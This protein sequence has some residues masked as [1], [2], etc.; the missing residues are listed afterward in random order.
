MKYDVFIS[1]KRQSINIV[2]A[3]EYILDN[4]GIKC[5]YDSGLEVS[6]G[7]DYADIIAKKISESKIMIAVLSN[8]ALESDWV[9]AEVSS[10]LEQKKLVI[11][12]IVGKIQVNNGLTLQ[13]RSKQW[14]DAYPNPDRKFELLLKNVK[15][16]L[17]ELEDTMD[18]GDDEKSQKKE[19][20]FT[21]E[22]DDCSTDFDYDEGMALYEGKEY[23][24][25]ALALFASAERGNRNAKNV[26]CQMFYDLEDEIQNFDDE[27]W[28]GIEQQA[29][30]N[31]CYANFLM[32]CKLYKEAS[33]NLVSFEYLKKA[34][35][36]NSVPLAFLRL[37]IQYSWGMGIKQSHTLGMHYYKKALDMGCKEAYSYMGQEYSMG[38]DK[39][40]KD[41]DK[42]ISL[43]NKGVEAGDQRSYKILCQTYLFDLKQKDE[44]IVV[45]SR[46]I[47]RGFL[48]GFAFM[49]DIALGDG[50]RFVADYDEAIKWYKK[51]LLN[52]EKSAY[53]ML[54]W[55]YYW[56]GEED[57]AILMAKKG[58]LLRDSNSYNFLA[59][60]YKNSGE[61]ENAWQCCKEWYDSVGIGADVMTELVLEN[62]YFPAEVE[63][64]EDKN[65]F[66]DRLEQIV[67]IQA[68][69]NSQACL[70]ALLK[71]YS[72]RENGKIAIDYSIGQRIPKAFEI[73]RIGAEMG[74]PEMMYYIGKGMMDN[75]EPKNY[76]PIKGLEWIG[77]AAEN[78]YTPAIEDLLEI[79][80]EGTWM[81]KDEYRKTVLLSLGNYS[82]SNEKAMKCL[83]KIS[84]TEDSDVETVK[85]FLESII[86][87]EHNKDLR[88]DAIKYILIWKDSLRWEP[89]DSVTSDIR[90]FLEAV[91][92]DND[93]GYIRL[94]GPKALEYF[95]EY[96]RQHGMDDFFNGRESVDADLF[97]AFALD[98]S[99][100]EENKIR[101]HDDILLPIFDELR[102]LPAV[103]R[104][105]EI[106][107]STY[108]GVTKALILALNNF[109]D[110]LNEIC[111]THNLECSIP[112]EFP[113][114]KFVPTM[115]SGEVVEIWHCILRCLYSLRENIPIINDLLENMN[116]QNEILDLA[117]KE[118][119]ENIQ[120][121]LIEIVEIAI[122]INEVLK[123][124]DELWEVVVNKEDE[125]FA[126]IIND[127]ARLVNE[128]VQDYQIPEFS[129][130]DA[131]NI[132][133]R[134]RMV[135]KS[136][137][138]DSVDEFS[139]LLDEFINNQH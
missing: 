44:A 130:E 103:N 45:A 34:I 78:G 46:A 94:I 110:A 74:M 136:I 4:A 104:F 75:S 82:L 3:I 29:R 86:H 14:I 124:N 108:E 27:I 28:D 18:S 125:K 115:S 35:R 90:Q 53:G 67:E 37:G 101:K 76:N 117:E 131:A 98:C 70:N 31:H 118:S 65:L 107:K 100:I 2:K 5:W 105:I 71:I 133:T 61:F 47:E 92:K 129:A 51:A 80:D 19:D 116:Y 36:K 66:L 84:V 24:E 119:D 96:S 135:E 126:A 42:A 79:Y 128:K 11:P 41:I 38:S 97:Y 32:H 13:L 120:L 23:N 17:N 20:R 15:I 83:K 52:N 106:E 43:L 109:V 111:S 57:T 12:F 39:I 69:N 93:Y 87:S 73:I 49:G 60:H 137:S 59:T 102:C 85:S 112:I 68:R 134:H 123:Y 21:I 16:A 8:A 81:D 88:A 50:D 63:S 99:I 113:I 56:L 132:R 139:R 54:A 55:V 72:F 122:E 77:K 1:Y 25:A 40:P 33:N 138:D 30:N 7:R 95:P 9:K 26:L 10:A 114:E 89:D 127:F 64:E 91:L 58:R 22:S 6:A 62:G 48:K 121:L